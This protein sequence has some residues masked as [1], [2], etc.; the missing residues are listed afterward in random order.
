MLGM[1]L[2]S[3]SLTMYPTYKAFWNVLM[4]AAVNIENSGRRSGL[5][6]KVSVV[7]TVYNTEQYLHRCLDSIAN[8]S[9]REIEV[10]VVNDGSPDGSASYLSGKRQRETR[11]SVQW[12]RRTAASRRRVI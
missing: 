4:M 10:V 11:A 2:L 8:Q 6:V 7:V 5:R 3:M 12:K 9:L 1:L